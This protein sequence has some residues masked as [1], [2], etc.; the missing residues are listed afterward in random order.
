MRPT[1]SQALVQRSHR[2]GCLMLPDLGRLPL[3][4]LA[5]GLTPALR[6]PEPYDPV[7]ERLGRERPGLLDLDPPWA[8]NWRP[9]TRLAR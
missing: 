4:A 7:P 5:F 6:E 9:S 1:R 8:M 3:C 2:G